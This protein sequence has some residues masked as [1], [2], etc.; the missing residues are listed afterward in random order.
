[1]LSWIIGVM[2][3][4]TWDDEE[5]RKLTGMSRYILRARKCLEEFPVP[6]SLVY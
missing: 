6:T 1:M 4:F 2:R 5:E 3:G